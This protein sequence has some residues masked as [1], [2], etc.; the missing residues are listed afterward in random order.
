MQI[1]DSNGNPL[2]KDQGPGSATASST[3]QTSKLKTLQGSTAINDFNLGF[4]SSVGAANGRLSPGKVSAADLSISKSF[5]ASSVSLFSS[6]A[7]GARLKTVTIGLLKNN[8]GSQAVY[9]VYSF[10]DAIVSSLQWSGSDD[11][12][13]TVSIAYSS[14]S[15]A[16]EPVDAKG[17]PGVVQQTNW[18]FM[19]NTAQ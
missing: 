16:F 6:L 15:V 11:V 1:T 10:T 5:D 8:A 2:I 12:S 14:V 18:N 3:W 17:S 13:E 19:T 4:S 7:A 9:A